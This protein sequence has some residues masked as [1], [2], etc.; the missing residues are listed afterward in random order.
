[1]LL[2]YGFTK[3][4]Q[5]QNAIYFKHDEVLKRK[6]QKVLNHSHYA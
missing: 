2:G 4:K 1:M 6:H 3:K 5:E